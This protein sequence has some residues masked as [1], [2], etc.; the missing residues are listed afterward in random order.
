[1]CTQAIIIQPC[2]LMMPSHSTDAVT[3]SAAASITETLHGVV[4][5]GSTVYAGGSPVLSSSSTVDSD[6]T[7][8]SACLLYT[9]DA[10]D[11]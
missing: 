8:D 1:M 11:E 2:P 10:A 7:P 5:P 4:S 9:S 6:A 3:A